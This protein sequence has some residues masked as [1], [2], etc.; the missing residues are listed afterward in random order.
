MNIEQHERTAHIQ[1]LSRHLCTAF[2]WLGYLLWLGWPLLALAAIPGTGFKLKH[3]SAGDI[4]PS[5]IYPLQLGAVIGAAI[6]LLFL[7]RFMRRMRDFLQHF[8]EGKIFNDNTIVAA[9]KALSSAV[10]LYCLHV[11]SLVL[12]QFYNA[13]GNPHAVYTVDPSPLINGMLFFGLMYL[14]LWTLE[15]GRDLNEEAVLT[16]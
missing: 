14:L 4:S 5:L 1:K 11:A 2:R 3:A 7:Q 15:I 9:R 8:S 12:M 10:V 6:L 16:V 13:I